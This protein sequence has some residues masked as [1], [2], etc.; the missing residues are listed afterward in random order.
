M[1]KS[2]LWYVLCVLCV[3]QGPSFTFPGGLG[4]LTPAITASERNPIAHNFW[5]C[6]LTLLATGV[7]SAGLSLLAKRVSVRKR[8]WAPLVK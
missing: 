5:F 6:V 4:K 7:D 2:I 1:Y 3:V 8:V